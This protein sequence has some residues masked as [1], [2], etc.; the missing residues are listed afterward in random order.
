[1]TIDEIVRHATEGLER[2]LRKVYNECGD[3]YLGMERG[4]IQY[5]DE[6]AGYMRTEPTLKLTITIDDPKKHREELL[7]ASALR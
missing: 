6:E 2:H 1:M 3:V 5:P 7:G 4:T